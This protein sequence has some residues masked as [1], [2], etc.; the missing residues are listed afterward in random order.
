MTNEKLLQKIGLVVDKLMNLGGSDYEKDKTVVQA[1]TRKGIVQRD[2]GIEEW[3]WPQGVGLYGLYKLQKYYGDQRYINFFR[4]WY[5]RNMEAGLPSK[6]INTTAPYLALVHL[7]DQLEP[8]DHLEQLCRDHAD[9]LIH[10]L[11]KTNEGG[12][13]HTVTAIGNRNGI[14]LHNGQIW[15]DTLFMA[16][17]FLNQAGRKFNRPEWEQEAVHQILLHMKYLFD[18]H[19]GLFFHGWSF[20]RNDNFGGIFWCRGNSW[21][22]YG[23][24][25]Y[26]EACRNTI[27]PGVRQYLVDTY[28]AQVHALVPLQA[29]SGLWH[30][31]LQDPT[32]YEEVSGSAAMAAGILKG[33]KTGLLDSSYQ[34]VADKTIQAVCQNIS[35][36]G[37]VMNVSAG[38]GMGMDQD[39]YKNIT[40]MPMAYGQSLALIALY[41]A[42]K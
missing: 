28:K 40:I 24:V 9:W 34:A 32:S 4:N 18:K 7:L 8:S 31:V 19:T 16:V 26:L 2:F 1:D 36:D 41:E 17:L 15:I 14:H 27:N 22:T 29:A 12:F 30:T 21:F 37:T 20:E 10:E 42:L 13:Q 6:N 5:S 3:D 33:I 11:P 39:H 38:T 23:I 35:G 25:D